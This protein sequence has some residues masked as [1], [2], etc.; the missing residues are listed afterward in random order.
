MAMKDSRRRISQVVFLACALSGLA[1]T[2]A[3][4][5]TDPFYTNLLAK[6]E[7]SFLARNYTEAARDFEIAAF[8]LGGNKT[9]VAKAHVYLGICRYYSKDIEASEKNM[10]EA[11]AIMG[12]EGLSKLGIHESARPAM[13]KLLAYFGIAQPQSEPLAGEVEVT[14]QEPEVKRRCHRR[15]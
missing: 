4:G 5:Q 1:A 14:P 10:Q 8:G 3:V 15:K 2:Q 6:A 7:K 13:E 12:D 11:A 9:L